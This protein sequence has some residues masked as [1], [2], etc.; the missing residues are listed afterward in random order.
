MPSVNE[1]SEREGGLCVDRGDRLYH[2]RTKWMIATF[3]VTDF[4]N[5]VAIIP[6]WA[7]FRYGHGKMGGNA[8][9]IHP[10]RCTCRSYYYRIH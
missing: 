9:G 6:F 3:T 10:S 1:K 4:S 8:W 7:V 2:D 5:P